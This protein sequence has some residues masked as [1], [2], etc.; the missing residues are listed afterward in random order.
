MV[1]WSYNTT[2]LPMVTYA[3]LAWWLK[4]KLKTTTAALNETQHLTC[5]SMT[6]PC[7]LNAL[8]TLRSTTPFSVTIEK[9]ACLRALSNIDK[10]EPGNLRSCLLKNFIDESFIK[11]PA[12]CAVK[13][14]LSHRDCVGTGKI[15]NPWWKQRIGTP[16]V[17]NWKM[18]K[19][20]LGLVARVFRRSYRWNIIRF[21]QSPHVPLNAWK[22][23][24]GESRS[25]FTPTVK[26]P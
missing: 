17:L 26:V 7:P 1:L 18:A 19:L 10:L 23:S 11:I 22:S 5:I 24:A 3:A 21:T 25:A 6:V 20:T 4:V 12:H 2:I 13:L 9:E 15:L 8:E 16:T 14:V